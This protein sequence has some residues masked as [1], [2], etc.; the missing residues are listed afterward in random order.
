MHIK[1]GTS[2]YLGRKG[3]GKTMNNQNT[4]I[5]EYMHFLFIGSR[6]RDK[7]KAVK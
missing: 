3:E 5:Y 7:H 1:M 6:E 4:H 2:E